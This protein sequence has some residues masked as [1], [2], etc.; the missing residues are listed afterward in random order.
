MEVT[1]DFRRRLL[2]KTDRSRRYISN[3]KG[4]NSEQR[5]TATVVQIFGEWAA[6]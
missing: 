3:E 4:I 6:K 2:E 5:K 1:V